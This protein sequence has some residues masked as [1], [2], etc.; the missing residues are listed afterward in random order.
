MN[1]ISTRL[2]W[3]TANGETDHIKCSLEN[4]GKGLRIHTYVFILATWTLA[5]HSSMSE[6]YSTSSL[7]S[8]ILATSLRTH[9]AS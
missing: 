7:S 6:I 1:F 5:T 2:V 3:E 8:S 4:C 9:L